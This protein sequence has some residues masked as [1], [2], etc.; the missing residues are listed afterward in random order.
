M[1]IRIGKVTLDKGVTDFSD[2]SVKPSFAASIQ[3]LNGEVN[4]MSSKDE[5]RATVNLQ[6]SVDN[7]AP[8][9]IKGEANFLSASTY[10]DLSLKFRN[11][12]LTTFNPYSG[13]YAG[14]DIDKGKLTTEIHYGIVD[15]KLT[16]QHH[17]VLD[18][19]EFGKATDSKDAVSIPVK[20]AVAL[21]KDRN[22][23]IELDLPVGG[24]LD[25]PDF[26]IGP[27]VWQVVKNLLTKIVTSPFAALGS[28]FGGSEEMSYVDF[29]VG[30]ATLV[31]AEKD[32]LSKLSR[33]LVER[34]QL[35][36]NIPLTVITDADVQALSQ[37]ALDHALAKHLP[38]AG[39][40]TAQQ[41]L[42]ALIAVY[43]DKTGNLPEF[44]S[45]S[46][47]KADTLAL[48]IAALRKQL[49]PM[50]IA[51]EDEQNELAT[52]R[53]NAVQDALLANTELSP[54]RVFKVGNLGPAKAPAGVARM[55][56]KLE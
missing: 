21:L 1:K 9:S 4:G 44:S 50:F 33:A 41:Q 3:N 42:D 26:R 37:T 51:G 7:Y 40:P 24:S 45:T 19:L 20:L 36:L 5:T 14:Y 23:V 6:G 54:E 39:A 2:D 34:P 49:V 17:V 22:G 11:I 10:S 15:R 48:Q 12:E 32:K 30:S 56:L 43:K 8:V 46:D 53:A 29:P 25:D 27:I 35:K 38:K 55:E 52:Q 31:D 47:K 18:Q 28:M 13:K 16:A